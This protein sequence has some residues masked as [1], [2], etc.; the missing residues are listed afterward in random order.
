MINLRDLTDHRYR[1]TLDE[2]ANRTPPRS[3]RLW[4][5]RIPCR[6]GHISVHGERSLAAFTNHRK[7]GTRPASLPGVKVHQRGDREMTVVFSPDRLDAVASLLKA[8]KRRQLSEAQRARLLAIS[9][10][11]PH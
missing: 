10:F 2:S 3:A 11:A 1:I 6:Y 4:H 9:P 8:R 5:Y 7:V